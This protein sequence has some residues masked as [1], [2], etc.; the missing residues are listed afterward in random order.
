LK[1][2]LTHFTFKPKNLDIQCVWYVKIHFNEFGPFET[3]DQDKTICSKWS[4]P[5]SNWG[6]WGFRCLIESKRTK[7]EME[8]IWNQYMS[9]SRPKITCFTFGS[10]KFEHRSIVKKQ[11]RHPYSWSYLKHSFKQT[12]DSHPN[13]YLKWKLLLAWLGCN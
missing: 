13:G 9:T 7:N 4:N 8:W 10:T 1:E 6:L 11:W 5:W 12:L 3:L 2:L